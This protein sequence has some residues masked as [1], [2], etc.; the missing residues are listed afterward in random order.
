MVMM[1]F[2]V[3]GASENMTGSFSR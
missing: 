1:N 3:P 2:V